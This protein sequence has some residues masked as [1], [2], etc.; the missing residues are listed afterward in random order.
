M[1]LITRMLTTVFS[2]QKLKTIRVR[3]LPRILRPGQCWKDYSF[4]HA[5]LP[6]A[7]SWVMCTGCFPMDAAAKGR[8]WTGRA[9]LDPVR[10]AGIKLNCCTV[11]HEE[12][13]A[14]HYENRSLSLIA[15]LGEIQTRKQCRVALGSALAITAYQ[16]RVAW[17]NVPK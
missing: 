2:S 7:S 5:W 17:H 12:L 3:F 8:R 16:F 11:L 6:V 10:P 1:L 13:E 4:A 15:I 14:T 9:I